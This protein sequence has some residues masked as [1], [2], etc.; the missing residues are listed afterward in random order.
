MSI[1]SHT[2]GPWHYISGEIMTMPG[3][4]KIG[5]PY[6]VKPENDEIE[7]NGRLMAAAPYLSHAIMTMLVAIKLIFEF[8]VWLTGGCLC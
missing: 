3:Q 4:V 2:P 6:P 5:R 7:S 1:G 8:I